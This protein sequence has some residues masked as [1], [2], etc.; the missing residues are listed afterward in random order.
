MSIPVWL[1]ELVLLSG[2]SLGACT[3]PVLQPSP[4]ESSIQLP[5]VQEVALAASFSPEV[6]EAS[7]GLVDATSCAWIAGQVDLWWT[8]HYERINTIW[9]IEAT[10]Q[11]IFTQDRWYGIEWWAYPEWQC[12]GKEYLD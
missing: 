5:Q 12:T 6:P 8:T 3:N 11:R 2:L 10:R 1:L 4:V 9:T 7:V